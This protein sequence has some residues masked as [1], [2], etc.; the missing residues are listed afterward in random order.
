MLL[1]EFLLIFDFSFW[2]FQRIQYFVD[3]CGRKGP[4][5]IVLKLVLCLFAMFFILLMPLIPFENNLHM[6]L[7]SDSMIEIVHCFYSNHILNHSPIL[8]HGLALEMRLFTLINC[9]YALSS[10]KFYYVFTYVLYPFSTLDR[11]V[12]VLAYLSMF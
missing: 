6:C 5:I 9:F 12:L 11:P 8:A 10:P 3:W 2:S 7:Y 1:L 4:K